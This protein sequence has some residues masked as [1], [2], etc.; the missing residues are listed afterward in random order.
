MLLAPILILIVLPVLI[1]MFS[2]RQVEQ[3]DAETVLEPAE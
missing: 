3:T 1:E 2:Q